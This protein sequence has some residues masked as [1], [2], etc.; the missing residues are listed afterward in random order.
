MHFMNYQDDRLESHQVGFIANLFDKHESR[1][2]REEFCYKLMQKECKWIFDDQLIRERLNQFIDEEVQLN[3]TNKSLVQRLN[4]LSQRRP[5]ILNGFEDDDAESEH[6]HDSPDPEDQACMVI[7][8]KE[9]EIKGILS[10][11]KASDI[12]KKEPSTSTCFR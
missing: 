9:Y 3:Q 5:S 7:A 10:Q 11:L 12:L 1:M 6:D 2:S 4:T 8:L